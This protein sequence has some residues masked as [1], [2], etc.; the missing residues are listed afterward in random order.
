[1]I[2]AAQRKAVDDLFASALGFHKATVPQTCQVGTDPR[3]WLA[4]G[5]YQLADTALLLF[6]EFQDVQPRR[7]SENPEE[8]RRSRA[9]SWG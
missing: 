1:L 2:Q 3:L 7:I 6:E 5:A 8:A 4:N 9:V